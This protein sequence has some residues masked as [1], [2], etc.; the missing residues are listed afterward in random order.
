MEQ[1]TKDK[2]LNWII[3][4]A[5][6]LL[7]A[8]IMGGSF[9][10]YYDLNDDVLIK[11]ILSGAYSG[12]PE[13]RNIQMQF[14]LSAVMAGLY[15]ISADIPW[16]GG[17]LYLCQYGSLAIIIACILNKLNI[18]RVF[19]RALVAVITETLLSSLM[20]GHI[21]NIQYTVTVAFMAAAALMLIICAEETA[22]YFENCLAVVLVFIAFLLRSEMLLLMLPFI[23][24]ACLYRWSALKNRYTVTV[25]I[26]CALPL[27]IM[28][29]GIVIGTVSNKM[30]YASEEWKSFSNLFDARTQ[31]YDFETIPSYED[32]ESFYSAI[33]MGASGQRLLENYNYGLDSDIDG[34][35]IWSIADYAGQVRKNNSSWIN[36]FKGKS[37]I[38]LYQITHGRSSTGSDYP[39][40]LIAGL[41]YLWIAE[42]II[43]YKRFRELW[44]LIILFAG[45]T[46]IWLYILMGERSPERI[47]HSLY[48]IEIVLLIA[49]FTEYRTKLSDF[50]IPIL[51]V[52]L[53]V[54]ILIDNVPNLWSNQADRESI[55]K[56]YIELYDYIGDHADDL[57][58][59]DVYST[60]AYS[61]Q[62]FGP[63][64]NI[65]KSNT[66][67]MGGWFYGSP[68][69]IKKLAKYGYSNMFGACLEG[70]YVVIRN[71]I[72]GINT[73]FLTD[74]YQD[75]G[76]DIEVDLI[77]KI[78]DVFE[79]YAVTEHIHPE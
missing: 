59:M 3:A 27:G 33:G 30:A 34:Q 63:D 78:A 40:N 31:L 20:L 74:Y 73:D 23:G 15:R 49:L 13:L 71:D 26:K 6:T 47:T 16:Y 10:Y 77:D 58:L 32:N 55:N 21:V 51:A 29:L 18:K 65:D 46:A 24:L 43:S 28:L 8:V 57:Y 60:V 75:C 41:L 44:K 76:L 9:D 61:E 54:T 38:Y 5:A 69:E 2:Y 50:V 64:S 11:D 48:F 53:S 19:T 4:A 12:I 25:V 22:G 45:R 36:K 68:V 42:G 79:I 66:E 62:L 39:Y 52:A 1:R 72:D 17:F 56:P 37:R 70:A 14:L 67:L 7:L 35:L